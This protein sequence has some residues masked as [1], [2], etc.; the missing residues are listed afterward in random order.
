MFSLPPKFFLVIFIFSLLAFSPAFFRPLPYGM[1][2]YYFLHEICGQKAFETQ[3]IGTI[4][5]FQ[6]LPCNILALRLVFFLCCFASAYFAAKT[7]S[8]FYRNGWLA[9]IFVYATPLWL[10][11]FWKIENDAIAFPIIFCGAYL[12]FKGLKQN[13]LKSKLAGVAL[14]AVAYTIWQGAAIWVVA[15]SL[16]WGWLA[17]PVVIGLLIQK[18]YTEGLMIK[19][20]YYWRLIGEIAPRFGAATE[21][22]PAYG[23]IYQAFLFMGLMFI[24]DIPLMVIPIAFFTLLAF[25][26][27]KFAVQASFL[28][29]IAATSQF[30]KADTKFVKYLP[31]AGAVVVSL[32]LA[33]M[34]PGL[35]PDSQELMAAKLAVN[36]AEGEVICNDWGTGHLITFLGGE[37][38]AKA[39]GKQ[40][41]Q[42]CQDCILL[43]YRKFDC[44][45]VND[46]NSDTELRVYKC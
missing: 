17:I 21:N 16:S 34:S 7:A 37:P 28:L 5:V 45:I 1:D 10:L 26:N 23:L 32:F 36:L 41:C 39:G 30:N 22:L 43:S 13:G 25:I 35:P 38:L 31:L 19:H 42:G 46:V 4:L 11:E 15:L 29:A 6:A 20:T 8:L 44:P 27:S 2:S 9:G 24:K 18:R 3:G 40:L 12:F 33:A 14:V